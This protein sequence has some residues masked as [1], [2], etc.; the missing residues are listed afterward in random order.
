MDRRDFL[1]TAA[2]SAPLIVSAKVLGRNR[3]GANEIVNVGLIGLGGRCK[4]MVKPC[5]KIPQ[6]RVVAVCD[7]FKPR[8]DEFMKLQPD[9]QKW[10]G[11]TD[12]RKMIERKLHLA[13][14]D[15]MIT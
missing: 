13:G 15:A 4:Y 8:V 11:Y 10:T 2:V 7:C 5:S 6:I 9:G 14:V 3:P 1:K 12:F